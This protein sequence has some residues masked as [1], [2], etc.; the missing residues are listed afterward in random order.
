MKMLLVVG[1]MVLGVALTGSCL[2]APAAPER[3]REGATLYVSKLG[4]NTDGKSWATAFQTIGAALEAVPDDLGGHRVVVRPDTYMEAMLSPAQKGAAGAY[5]ELVGDVDGKYGSGRTGYVVLDSSDP[6]KGFKSYDWYGPIRAYQQGWSKEHTE[7]TQSAIAWDRWIVRN[8]YVTGGDGG[9]FWDMTDH[10]EPFTIIVEDCISIG[11]AFGGGV[12]NGLSRTDEPMVFRRC[13]LWALDWWGDTAAAYVRVENQVMPDRPD[14]YFEDCTMAS[15]QCALKGGNFGFKTFVR[16]KLERC[17][18]VALNFSQ[19]QGTPIDGAIQS[20]EEGQFLHVDLEDT[21]V[22]GYK[23]FGVRVN[24]E[25]EKDLKFTTKGDVRAYVQFQQ[26]VPAGFH[27]VTQWPI[28]AFQAI[29]PP[30]PP[31]PM[32]TLQDVSLVR[33]DMCELSPV[34]WGGRLCHMACVRPGS[35][36]QKSD[37]YLELTDAETGEALAKFAEG[38]GLGCALVNDGVFYAFA[39][40]FEEGNWND[41][42][43][44]KSADLQNWESTVVIEQENEHLF[45]SSVCAGPDGFVMAYESNDPRWPAFTTKFARSKDLTSWEKLPDCGFGTNRYTACP[46]VRYLGGY[47]YVL[48]LESR[49]PVHRFEMYLTRSKDLR[50]WEISSTSPILAPTAI[51]D[52]INTSDPDLEEIDGK[53]W[54]YYAVG[55]QLSWMNIKRGSFPGTLR[56]FFEQFYKQPGV[57]DYGT[58]ARLKTTG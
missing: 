30:P 53:T 37:Y 15:P 2:A 28:E 9:L 49:A 8:L 17:R 16:V 31:A 4:D 58:F 42:T 50:D 55:D 44:F 11:R 52:G 6:A 23:V 21:T 40:R 56:E 47:Y 45:N 20:V 27:R 38:Y 10:T 5:N 54:L 41:V 19:P 57:P 3:G 39:S 22:M 33:K 36:G 1:A 25:T 12:G 51:D 14:I 32:M 46:C 29:A 35:G 13:N 18:L 48:Y 26:D 34:T 24:K 43:M 7:E